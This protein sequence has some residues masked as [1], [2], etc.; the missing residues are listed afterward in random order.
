MNKL[1]SFALGA[2]LALTSIG[3][4][5]ADGTVGGAWKLTVGVTD[6]P[7]TLTL[8]PDA[9]GTAGTIAS[10][11]D[12]PSYLYQAT[13]WKVAGSG[14]QLYA[15]SGELIASLKPHGDSYVGTRFADGRKLAL[16]R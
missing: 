6:D 13:A 11:S 7:C 14:I 16:S 8:T 15:G 1:R 9:S 5:H 3:I 12:C 2:A 4:A 10:G